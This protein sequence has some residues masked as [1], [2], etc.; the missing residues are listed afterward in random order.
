TAVTLHLT[1]HELNRGLADIDII[2]MC[3]AVLPIAPAGALLAIIG[4]EDTVTGFLLA[5]VGDRT[6]GAPNFLVV[7]NSMLGYLS[8]I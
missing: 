2:S 7:D 6:A 3:A 1:H 8:N 4:D 5:G